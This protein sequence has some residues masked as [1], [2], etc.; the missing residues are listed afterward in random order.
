MK[1]VGL[2]LPPAEGEWMRTTISP[3]NHKGEVNC[4]YVQA[5]VLAAL[6]FSLMALARW[7]I[8]H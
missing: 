8:A 4:R 7:F 5:A 1:R 3:I 2:K 6:V